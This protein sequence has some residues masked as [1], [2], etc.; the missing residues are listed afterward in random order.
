M[1]FEDLV[2]TS[3]LS[4]ERQV[5]QWLKD[6]IKNLE[7]HFQDADELRNVDLLILETFVNQVITVMGDH[8]IHQEHGV[9]NR[10]QQGGMAIMEF[11]LNYNEE[12]LLQV[13]KRYNFLLMEEYFTVVANNL[14]NPKEGRCA[15]KCTIKKTC[16]SLANLC[17]DTQ[18]SE[19]LCAFL[20]VQRGSKD[21]LSLILRRN[22]N[23][24]DAKEPTEE[25]LNALGLLECYQAQNEASKTSDLQAAYR[26]VMK[27]KRSCLE[28]E[29]LEESE[30]QRV[31]ETIEDLQKS[32]EALEDE[33]NR[34]FKRA[35]N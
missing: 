15:N 27:H 8:S 24:R 30:K 17:K 2:S 29:G 4:N 3:S 31:L 5:W 10:V 23:G 19:R 18:V 1:I 7:N 13:L 35:R 12:V 34:P 26:A 11:L 25:L 32:Y 22:L 9:S 28:K 21:S 16:T 33:H 20:E 6:T 14:K